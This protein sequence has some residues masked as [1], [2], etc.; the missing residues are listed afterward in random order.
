M[1]V[2][3]ATTNGTPASPRYRAPKSSTLSRSLSPC[4]A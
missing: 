3:A 4:P 2:A 1:A